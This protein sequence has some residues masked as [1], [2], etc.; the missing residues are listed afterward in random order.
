MMEIAWRFPPS[1]VEDALAQALPEPVTA[2][3]SVDGGTTLHQAMRYAVFGGGK[4]LRSQLVMEAA[5]VVGGVDFDPRQALPAACALEM[6]HAYSLVHDD[7]PAMD[8]ADTRRGRPSCHK[9]FG[10]AIAIL[11]GD[12]LLTLAFE[13]LASV[14]NMRSLDACT[15]LRA[16]QL[17]ARAAG[18]AGMVG[19]QA[20]DIVWSE[21][22]ATAITGQQVLHMHALKTGALIRAAS[23]V[24]AL[25][26]GGSLEQIQAL[27]LYGEHLGRAFQI[28][29]D[30]LDVEGD[31]LLTG[32]GATDVANFKTT[33]PAVLGLDNSKR[34]AHEASEAAIAALSGCGAEATALRQLAKFVV[35]REK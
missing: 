21:Q 27:R 25:L 3:A 10:E 1:L 4:R 32:K 22:R 24:G 18:E 13:T 34:L 5:G 12:A 30:V 19:G 7:L 14:A 15:V 33:A 8:N 17:I 35:Q 28:H 6:I 9:A 2:G 26:G 31:P 20:I 11:A 29:D 23:E 16:T